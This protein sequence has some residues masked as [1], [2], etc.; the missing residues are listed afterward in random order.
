MAS[1][2]CDQHSGLVEAIENLKAEN[3]EFRT[4]MENTK[5]EITEMRNKLFARLNLAL[6]GIA[7]S[8]VLLVLN[9]V[10]KIAS[11]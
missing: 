7:A 11:K 4:S 2:M 5:R 6:G 9:L 10:V 1:E 8:C 3:K